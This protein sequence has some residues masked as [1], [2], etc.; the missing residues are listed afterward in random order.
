MHD[1]RED[2]ADFL[3]SRR[4][5]VSPESAGLERGARRRTPGLRRSEVAVL[6][7]LSP[8]WYT[9]LEQGRDVRPSREVLDRLADVLHLSED[10]RL[11]LH[12][13]VHGSPSRAAALA[14]IDDPDDLARRFIHTMRD[15]AEP[16]Y[17]V[18]RYADIIAMN[19]AADTWYPNMRAVGNAVRWLLLDPV[20]RQV[21]GDWELDAADVV[22]RFRTFVTRWGTDERLQSM[23]DEYQR[24]SPLFA[25]VWAAQ[26]VQEHRSRPRMLRL[27]GLAPVTFRLLVMQ[28]SELGG[29]IVVFHIATD[30]AVGGGGG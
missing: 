24:L 6:A 28:A 13:L 16:V 3:R 14:D 5:R 7:G 4:Q 2:L 10:E 22:A 15:N 27:A 29:R 1:D 12:S 9:Y 30:G 11:H 20:A 26:S 19:P 18:N 23:I 25:D 17:S 21:V 8:T